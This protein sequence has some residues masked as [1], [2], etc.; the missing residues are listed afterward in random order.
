M[1]SLKITILSLFAACAFQL[2]AQDAKPLMELPKKKEFKASEPNFIASVDWIENT[3]FDEQPEMHRH[4]Y[5][6][7]VG[8]VSDSPTVTVSLNGYILDYTKK[9]KELLSFFMG[10]WGRYALQNNY[11]E[12]ELQ[13]N[14]AGLRSMIRIYR[15]GK[16]NKDD[17][18]QELVDLDAENKLEEWVKEK[19]KK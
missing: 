8:W 12:D 13:G 11:S 18:M 4:Q 19:L 3:P 2:V 10:G 1:R 16:L 17:A 6:M 7:I 15:T 14:L 9:N 5:A